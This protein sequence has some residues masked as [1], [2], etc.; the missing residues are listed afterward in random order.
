[1]L[2]KQAENKPWTTQG[3][4]IDFR[5]NPTRKAKRDYVFSF[6][7]ARKCDHP[8]LQHVV[9]GT[10]FYRCLE[11]NYG[12]WIPGGSEMW[13]LHW[14]PIMGAMFIGSFVKEF[15]MAALEQVYRTPIGQVDGTPHKPVLK[16]GQ[17]FKDFLE[18]LDDVDVIK[19]IEEAGGSLLA[20]SAGDYSNGHIAA[21]ESTPT[22]EGT[23]E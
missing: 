16:E 4:G 11:C 17:S 3:S 13:P 8:R 22:E 14:T 7:E 1:V 21:E 6:A 20:L 18:T 5:A 2:E 23:T 10:N 9:R 19:A 12:F 15:G